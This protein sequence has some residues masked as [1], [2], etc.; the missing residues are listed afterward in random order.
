MKNFSRRNLN[1][2]KD[3]CSE[4]TGVELPESKPVNGVKIA[5]IVLAIILVLTP[6]TAYASHYTLSLLE[7]RESE[8][9][10][11]TIAFDFVNDFME[12]TYGDS[13]S[14]VKDDDIE[15]SFYD[16]IRQSA[17]L[18]RKDNAPK[19]NY[20][21]LG[22]TLSETIDAKVLSVNNMDNAW[23]VN[24]SANVIESN[25]TG[26]INEYLVTF[27]LKYEGSGEYF[28]L[29]DM[30]FD[31]TVGVGEE[32]F[33]V[34]GAMDTVQFKT[35][36][37]NNNDYDQYI[38]NE[39]ETSY[40]QS[41]DLAKD[42]VREFVW[43]YVHYLWSG[44]DAFADKE[45][46]IYSII[47]NIRKIQII[48][49]G[50]NYTFKIAEPF[51]SNPISVE[52]TKKGDYWYARGRIHGKV[53]DADGNHVTDYGNDVFLKF[54][55][56][57]G[58]YVVE[59]LNMFGANNDSSK[60]FWLSSSEAVLS[61]ESFIEWDAS[62]D[63]YS[64]ILENSYTKLNNIIIDNEIVDEAAEMAKSFMEAAFTGGENIWDN[65]KNDDLTVFIREYVEY[66]K[67]S[68]KK[69]DVL[70]YTVTMK[71]PYRP[72]VNGYERS[73]SVRADVIEH[74]ADGTDYT[75]M[76]KFFF[77]YEVIGSNIELVDFYF[78]GTLPET[79]E[80]FDKVGK[81][82]YSL[83]EETFIEWAAEN[84]DYSVYIQKV[85]DAIANLDK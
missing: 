45:G 46:I 59:G 16:F 1:N 82:N 78:Y 55:E 12:F 52:I 71:E 37:E 72:S 29:T 7:F 15:E 2:I 10:V 51:E 56:V 39:S 41:E 27:Y 69:S 62:L 80:V 3:I 84:N 9:N 42:F 33:G 19:S 38:K 81:N 14:Y 58:E 61:L 20:K 85:K 4:K 73:N 54:K 44:K 49:D 22:Y 6:L 18:F 65:G 23:Y 11:R 21:V 63:D 79:H 5:S 32:I 34:S 57:D 47:D 48:F 24:V 75:H 25:Y 26:V 67:L 68:S 8:E 83:T 76:M 74:R 35:W 30:Y 77:N 13:F 31:D 60:I 40:I 64:Q 70:S 50:D 43:D 66:L 53:F 36:C 17:Y 28:V